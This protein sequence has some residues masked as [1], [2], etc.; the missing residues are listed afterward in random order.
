MKTINIPS[1]YEYLSI[2]DFANMFNIYPD[3]KLADP[4]MRSFS[5][6]KTLIIKNIDKTP[7]TYFENY[8]PKQT[9]SWLLISFYAYDTTE[10]WWL[11]CK[12]NRITDPT[13]EPYEFE[14]LKIL[15]KSYINS[16]LK[17]IRDAK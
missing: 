1:L 13:I 4:N 3:N 16:I 2:Y 5:I 15:K 9:D 14:S 11:I 6:N 7:P 10:L 8:N 17:Q 12:T